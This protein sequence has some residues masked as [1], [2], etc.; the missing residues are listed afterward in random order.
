MAGGPSAANRGVER[1]HTLLQ[2]H[3]RLAW[4]RTAGDQVNYRRFRYQRTGRAAVE[5]DD[6][7][8]AVHALPLRLVREG[9]VDGLRVDHVD[10]LSRP[11]AYLQRE[12]IRTRARPATVIRRR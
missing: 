6:V 7:F 2:Q 9:W 10:G 11:G 8:E 1:L 12:S 5:R 4:W 3:Y